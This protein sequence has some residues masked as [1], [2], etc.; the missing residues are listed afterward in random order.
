MRFTRPRKVGPRGT[1]RYRDR[2]HAQACKGP[3][4]DGP[5]TAQHG[6]HCAE[7]AAV[8]DDFLRISFDIR[9]WCRA[10]WHVGWFR[11]P[12]WEVVV[13]AMKFLRFSATCRGGGI[14]PCLAPNGA[15]PNPD[16]RA[17]PLH[18]NTPV[19]NDPIQEAFPK[20]NLETAFLQNDSQS[21]KAEPSDRCI[22]ARI[23]AGGRRVRASIWRPCRK[24]VG[25]EKDGPAASGTP[26]EDCQRQHAVR[27][28]GAGPQ[29]TA[30]PAKTGGAVEFLSEVGAA[31]KVSRIQIRQRSQQK[32]RAL[33]SGLRALNRE[34]PV[35]AT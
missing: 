25:R 14:R 11:S 33:H 34:S 7:A 1:R 17:M 30:R 3:A 35:R 6:L 19:S 26:R 5:G 24:S 2:K 15:T 12:A 16:P 8:R 10:P 29:G 28:R 23:D 32:P 31:W 21:I 22:P 20:K 4:A 27:G 9:S 13:T 18:W